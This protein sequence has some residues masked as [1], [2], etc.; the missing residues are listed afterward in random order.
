MGYLPWSEV[1]CGFD[2]IMKGEGGRGKAEGGL[3]ICLREV[4]RRSSR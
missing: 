2:N 1:V 4:V 3:R